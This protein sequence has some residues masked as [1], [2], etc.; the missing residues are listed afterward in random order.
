MWARGIP[1]IAE[2]QTTFQLQKLSA[3]WKAL[4]TLQHWR[5]RMGP[6]QVPAT[7]WSLANRRRIG[8][9]WRLNSSCRSLR[10]ATA[11]TD[12][13]ADVAYAV[14]DIGSTEQRVRGATRKS[15]R[16]QD[17]RSG[18]PGTLPPA[19]AELIPHRL[20]FAQ[21]PGK[22]PRCTPHPLTN[23][24]EGRNAS[25]KSNGRSHHKSDRS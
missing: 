13:V 1:R 21:P 15:L 19:V 4:P 2:S 16:V 22:R 3:N 20:A 9:K 12:T 18:W 11:A 14:I 6:R 17:R 8:K 23:A 5:K 7:M 25:R 24:G 10:N